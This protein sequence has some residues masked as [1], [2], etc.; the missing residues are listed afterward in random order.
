VRQV[1]RDPEARYWGG[2]VEQRALVPL[3]E[4][5]LGHITSDEWF[6]RVQARA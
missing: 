1:V 6:R 5:R 2:R 4:P 3:G